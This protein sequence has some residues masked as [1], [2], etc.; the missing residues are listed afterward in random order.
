[1]REWRI[2]AVLVSPESFESRKPLPKQ[3]RELRDEELEKNTGVPDTVFVHVSGFIGGRRS[4]GEA[5]GLD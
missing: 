4:C 5:G 2:Q 1:M 3:W